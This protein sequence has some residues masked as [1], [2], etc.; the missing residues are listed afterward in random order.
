MTSAI[1]N[2]DLAKRNAVE[3]GWHLGYYNFVLAIAGKND[4]SDLTGEERQVLAVI[5]GRLGNLLAFFG[6]EAEIKFPSSP[7]EAR[8]LFPESV[9]QVN[10][11]STLHEALRI[12]HGTDQSNLFAL[13]Q[14]IFSYALMAQREE[15]EL[16]IAKKEQER[17]I[18]RLMVDAAF[19]TRA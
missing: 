19:S 17:S 5:K 2:H 4:G 10:I 16:L 15:E 8:T 1:P 9:S 7:A 3:L 14:T 6:L 13:G 18:R 12:R 11:S